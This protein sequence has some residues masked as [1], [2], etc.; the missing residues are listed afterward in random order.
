MLVQRTGI[1]KN[2][3]SSGSDVARVGQR[4]VGT[5]WGGRCLGSALHRFSGINGM[6]KWDAVIYKKHFLVLSQKEKKNISFLFIFSFWQIHY[7]EMKSNEYVKI[8]REKKLNVLEFSWLGYE[9]CR[10]LHTDGGVCACTLWTPQNSGGDELF[11]QQRWFIS[12][13]GDVSSSP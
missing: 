11:F 8:L 10:V 4:V 12:R 2:P 5:W 6:V 1:Q 7:L 13:P 3:S 9:A